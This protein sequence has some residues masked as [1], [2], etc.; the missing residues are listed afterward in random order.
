MEITK[1]RFEKVIKEVMEDL[2][3]DDGL[4]DCMT[5]MLITMTGV[6]FAERMKRKLFGEES[7]GKK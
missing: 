1:K 5:R 2:E 3:H 6:T 4:D 7:E